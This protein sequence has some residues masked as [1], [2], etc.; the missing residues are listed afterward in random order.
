MRESFLCMTLL[1]PE[2]AI[3][4]T[5]LL[6]NWTF[7]SYFP[8]K[9]VGLVAGQERIGGICHRWLELLYEILNKAKVKNHHNLYVICFLFFT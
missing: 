1:F 3:L 8:L 2:I 6:N 4:T 5:V 9:K 7:I